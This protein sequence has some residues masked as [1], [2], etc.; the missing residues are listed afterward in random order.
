MA[1]GKICVVCNHVNPPGATQCVKCTAPMKVART[2]HISANLRQEIARER[3]DYQGELEAGF[4]ALH[5]VGR[6]QPL[7]VLVQEEVILGRHAGGDTTNVVDLSDFRAGLLGVS[8][9]HAVVRA[10]DKGY[11]IEDKGST[12]G[13]WVNEAPLLPETPFSLANGDCIRLGELTMYIYFKVS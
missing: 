1:S 10:S 4:I 11:E 13:S 5:L 12:N 9:R 7:H 3:R 2:L 8:R 6:R